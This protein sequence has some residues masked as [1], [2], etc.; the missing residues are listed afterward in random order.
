M[1]KCSV[2][3]MMV[4]CAILV[5]VFPKKE[6]KLPLVAIANYG[7]HNTLIDSI[8]GIKDSLAKAGFIEGKTVRFAIQDVGFDAALIPQMVTSLKNQHPRVMIALTTPVAQFAKSAVHDIPV[9]YDVI[10]DPVEAGLIDARNQPSGNMTGSSDQQNLT[11]LLTFAQKILPKVDAVG[12]LY[13]PSEA[14]DLALKKAFEEAAQPFHIKLIAFPIMDA[15]DVALVMPKFKN[16]VDMIYVGA[17]GPIQPALPVIAAQ[18][19]LLHIPVFNVDEDAV[20]KGLVLAS[21]GVNY[22][23]VGVH[24]GRLAVHQ[25]QNEHAPLLKPVY[26]KKADHHGVIHLKNADA[27]HLAIPKQLENITIMRS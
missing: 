5:T 1:K 10:T 4:I 2:I 19:A 11:L 24:A 12:L 9:I 14:N 6:R 22:Y 7:P 27:L 25:L 26:P 13:A 16:K 20:R 17:S 3:F 8:Q 18:S 15:R 23:Q 21:F